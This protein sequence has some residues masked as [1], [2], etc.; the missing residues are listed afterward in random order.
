MWK[1]IK[2]NANTVATTKN[3]SSELLGGFF[4]LCLLGGV[5]YLAYKKWKNER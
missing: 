2:N 3:D 4:V 1:C 5:G